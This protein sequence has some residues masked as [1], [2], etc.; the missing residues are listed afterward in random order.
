MYHRTAIA[1]A[2]L[3]EKSGA[4][5]VW[6]PTEVSLYFFYEGSSTR[7][8]DGDAPVMQGFDGEPKRRAQKNNPES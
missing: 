4:F 8:E 7:L 5:I 1:L 6:R 3:L 2:V